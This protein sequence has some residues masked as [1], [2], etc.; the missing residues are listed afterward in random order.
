M[1]KAWSYYLFWTWNINSIK[2]L[3]FVTFINDAGTDIHP[4]GTHIKNLV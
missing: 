4:F 1:F 2:C 3:F